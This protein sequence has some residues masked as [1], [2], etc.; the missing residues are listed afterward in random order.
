MPLKF[1]IL[2]LLLSTPALAADRLQSEKKYQETWCGARGGVMEYRLNNGMRVD[3]LTDEY[4][5]EMDFANKWYE[6]FGQALFYAK[7]TKRKPAV[8]L[9]IENK[10][11]W[12]Y[13]GRLKSISK[14]SGLKIWYIEGGETH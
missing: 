11:D 10:N 7:A 1:F 9:I 8:V 5:V 12:I 2:F 14:E 13:Y 3:C 4:A 6:S